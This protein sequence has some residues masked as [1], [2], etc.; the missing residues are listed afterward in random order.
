MPDKVKKSECNAFIKANGIDAKFMSFAGVERIV[1]P[2]TLIRFKDYADAMAILE[3][4]PKH[5]PEE[6]AG[7]I[8]INPAAMPQDER[9]A[10]IVAMMDRPVEVAA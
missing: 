2:T 1:T 4:L 8:L 6:S 9:D 7:E 5:K 3:G 10:A